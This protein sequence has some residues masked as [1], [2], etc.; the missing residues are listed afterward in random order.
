MAEPTRQQSPSARDLLA[1]TVAVMAYRQDMTQAQIARRLVIS[2]MQ[3][4]RL[5]HHAENRG[6]VCQ[7][8]I[9]VPIVTEQAAELLAE[10]PNIV[11]VRVAISHP[12]LTVESTVEAVAGVAAELCQD[13]IANVKPPL[14]MAFGGGRGMA[15]LADVVE[16]P[17]QDLQC[18][19]LS[20][21]PSGDWEVSADT[22]LAVLKRRYKKIDIHPLL[23]LQ[24]SDEMKEDQIDVARKRLLNLGCVKKH[25][26]EVRRCQLVFTG[27]GAIEDSHLCERLA[28]VG[29][30]M[31]DI[32]KTA[33]GDISYNIVHHDKE[34]FHED[35]PLNR[36][37]VSVPME[38]LREI[39]STKG[40]RVTVVAW[41]RMKA[42]PILDAYR[43]GV[44]NALVVDIE[45]A[46]EM[47]N[48]ISKGYLSE[49]G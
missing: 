39:A 25:I 13:F 38:I 31:G 48:Q 34:V 10:L 8:R 2:R 18:Y 36:R 23:A 35:C 12:E 7:P 24:V 22:N 6:Y 4:S 14:K 3:V 47:L 15:T 1:A 43:A 19:A 46:N 49:I 33:T 37:L 45:L 17:H 41:G 27:A 32:R 9:K 21:L 11:Q 26:D 44:F 30:S 42:R 28:S 16:L 5:L 20:N 29:V 40:S